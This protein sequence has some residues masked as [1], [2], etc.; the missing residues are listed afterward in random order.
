MSAGAGASVGD[1]ADALAAGAGLPAGSALEVTTSDG[2]TVLPRASDA[3]VRGGAVVAL[4]DE[5]HAAG[6]PG[7][8]LQVLTG[9]DQG[10]D[11]RLPRGVT[12]IGRDERCDVRLGDPMLSRTHARVLV[13]AQVEIADAGSSTGLVIG[14]GRV[15]RA[16]VDAGDY[17]LLGDSV[18]R[19]SA[20]DASDE[21]AA[22]VRFN[23][24]PRVLDRFDEREVEAPAPPDPPPPSRPPWVAILAPLVMG[25]AMYCF[26]R[27]PLTLALLAL[28]PLV[29]FATWFDRRA[30]D[31][32]RAREQAEAFRADLAALG[33]R[34]GALQDDERSVRLAEAPSTDEVCAGASSRDPVLWS[35]R[36]ADGVVV[37]VGV[38]DASSRVAVRVPGRGRALD[39]V[40]TELEA[41]V[42]RHAEARGVPLLAP[43]GLLGVVGGASAD[44][45]ARAVM[46][47]VV[48]LH[49]PVEVGVGALVPAAALGGWSWLAWVPHTET[50]AGSLLAADPAAGA[51]L[52]ARLEELV[53]GR[54]AGSGPSDGPPTVVVL[55]HDDA[56]A[57]RA[58]LVRL[59]EV[60][61][62]HGVHLVWLAPDVRRLPA[63]FGTYVEVTDAAAAVGDVSGGTRREVRAERLDVAAAAGFA[64]ALAG[65]EDAGAVVHDETALPRS[66][67]FLELA[68]RDV[69]SSTAAVLERWRETGTGRRGPDA[70]LRAVVGTGSGGRLVLDLRA[71]GPHALV[72]GTT[73]SGKSEL[74]QTWV[75]SL[76]V[77]YGPERVTFL[78]VDYKGGAAFADCVELPHCVGLVTDLSPPLVR[79]AL[80]SLRA[81]L[82]HREHLFRRKG[83][84]D[85]LE[86]ERT[87]D[88]ETP[89]AL[90]IVVDE[91]AA[92]VADVPEFVDGVVDVAQRGRSLGLHLVLATQRPAGVIK[93]N[94]R[95]NTNL[96]VAL[97]MAD[98]ADSTDV[99][100]TPIAAQI[101]PA[102]PGRGAVRTGP[103]RVAMFQTA[104]AGGVSPETPGR[105]SVDVA[106][107]GFGADEPWLLPRG[108]MADDDGPTDISRV[109]ATVRAAAAGRHVPRRPWLPELPAVVDL[110]TL[111]PSQPDAVTLGLADRPA[112]QEQTVMRWRPDDHGSLA[113]FGTS[114]AGRSAVLRTVAASLVG[115]AHVY[116][117]DLGSGGL[118]MLD[119]LPHVGAVIDGSD[120]ERTVRLLRR[121]R[122]ELDERAARF[123]AAHADSL[124]RYRE[125]AGRDDEPRVVL[126]VD[127]LAALRDAHEADV[128]RTGAWA[129]FQRVVAEGRPLGIHVV[130]ACERPG[131]LPTSLAAG[132]P[133]RLVLRQ[134]DESAYGLLGV[135]KDVL[136]PASP[137]GRAV[138]CGESD[139]V[140]VA[141]LGGDA[142][143]G[144]Q[145]AALALLACSLTAAGVAPAPP[146]R[147]LPTLVRAASLPR[148]AA[149]Q[150]VLGIAD[151]TLEPLGFDPTGSFLLAGPPGSGRTTALA[152]IAT[153]VR[154]WSPQAPLHLVARPRSPLLALGGWSDVATDPADAA[155]LVGGL[156]LESDEQRVTL[157]VESL[158][159]LLGTAAEQP[160]TAAVRAA[161]RHG[162]L[163]VAEA[164]T[165]AWSSSWPLFAEVRA[166]RRGLVLQPDHLDGDALLRTPFLRAPR[167]E[168]PPGRGLLVEA[169]RV[170]RV[171]V[172]CP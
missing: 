148:D 108:P 16:V 119:V 12:T 45:V 63:A 47:Q 162:H 49:S 166:G 153:A 54:V 62:A 41:L 1:V 81:E 27:S 151:D 106:T 145:A 115:P 105:P 152:A 117:L 22:A 4:V 142:D 160:V 113:V 2:T 139:E 87:G 48:G 101:D 28:S 11:V 57:D 80:T 58:R 14:G 75:L 51:A 89:P 19:I 140:Q 68:G 78:L 34:L 40:W 157:V 42:A 29:A 94:L 8:R 26:L 128:G 25:V 83:V 39:E 100:G 70:G 167:G 6:P 120:T 91:F 134:A 7:A 149:G 59:A 37:R 150:P 56:P 77:A 55:V 72:G 71:Q 102:L 24:S 67:G 53:A 168:Q 18:L 21:P 66:V 86:L 9:P 96:R 165:A 32:R 121:L 52:V 104:H 85:L 155:A 158:G 64:R 156:P 110:A 133:R 123:A 129:A 137:P 46:A 109:V 38:G 76:A 20:L 15:E 61:P 122:D 146:V 172:A 136:G 69:A 170:R 97:R 169:G 171:Q 138:P 43:L 23:R 135:P 103:G 112:H 31:R 82:R 73:G 124:T 10:L 118:A 144:A 98:D 125:V 79:R 107:L 116:G 74:L 141:V 50:S 36:P 92:L 65:I 44:D 111:E 35:R 130:M 33:A 147:R 93:D 114:G 154:R 132:V 95:A 84:K 159:D 131:A 164:E 143:P 163:V 5:A 99:L 90:V 161:R 30:S 88:P 17:V 126:L 13:G 60:G 127:G 3:A